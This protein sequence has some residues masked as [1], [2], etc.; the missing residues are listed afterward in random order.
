MTT[1]LDS[2]DAQILSDHFK[3]F[4]RAIA[5]LAEITRKQDWAGTLV[6][7]TRDAIA[8]IVGNHNLKLPDA[9]SV[10]R[11]FEWH[12]EAMRESAI[13]MGESGWY[14]DMSMTPGQI[15]EIG[16]ALQEGGIDEVNDALV[17]YFEERLDQIEASLVQKF[18]LRARFIRAAFRAH[19][20]EEYE[21]AIPLLLA[22]I[23]GICLHVTRKSLFKNISKKPA[24]AEYV[25][26]SLANTFMAALLSPLTTSL[27]INAS[28][29]QRADD[30]IAL[31]RH[32]VL[33][34]EALDY[35]TKVNSLKVIS[36][37]NYIGDA[38]TRK[39][40]WTKPLVSRRHF[41]NL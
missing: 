18:S 3:E 28:E 21:L 5:Q 37:I 23:D 26:R 17:A 36:L 13:K 31:N 25:E 6:V 8:S 30:F 7:G 15:V 40:H 9:S 27:P 24:I 20:R 22:Q 29:S 35:D 12:T 2:F 19:R 14:L 10:T 1:S 16:N 38:L 11:F 33:H 34:G 41:D 32:L 4:Q 39:F